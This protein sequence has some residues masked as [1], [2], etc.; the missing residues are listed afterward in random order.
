MKTDNLEGIY[1][2]I[3][4]IIKIITEIAFFFALVYK[5]NTMKR[6]LPCYLVI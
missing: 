6:L 3:Q 1:P 4:A 5:N 2:V